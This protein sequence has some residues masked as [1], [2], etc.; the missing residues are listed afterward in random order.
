MLNDFSKA[1]EKLEKSF[2]KKVMALWC[3]AS[4]FSFCKL[5]EK[6]SVFYQYEKQKHRWE[7]EK[8]DLSRNGEGTLCFCLFAKP[9]DICRNGKSYT[10]FCCKIVI[11]MYYDSAFH[12]IS[13]PE[14]PEIFMLFVWQ[15]FDNNRDADDAVYD[16]NGKELLGDRLTI[17]RNLDY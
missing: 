2:W 11:I 9:I 4:L 6:S 16:L 10:F 8:Q 15:E 12:F 14:W 3:V 7:I 17:H 13:L 1:T 5:M